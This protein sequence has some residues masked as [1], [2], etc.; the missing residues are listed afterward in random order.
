[1]H[2]II[3][4]IHSSFKSLIDNNLLLLAGIVLACSI[5]D[6]KTDLPSIKIGLRDVKRPIEHGSDFS[7]SLAVKLSDF[8]L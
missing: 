1:M 2:R 6:S 3:I 5:S 4:I 8:M 7:R